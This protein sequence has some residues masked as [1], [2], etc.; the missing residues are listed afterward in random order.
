M[1][2]SMKYSISRSMSDV[3]VS[4]L[5]ELGVWFV[6][7]LFYQ[8]GIEY[9]AEA[10]DTTVSVAAVDAVQLTESFGF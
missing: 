10:P 9:Q 2:A 6:L 4:A 5:P 1:P 8:P 7:G 3:F